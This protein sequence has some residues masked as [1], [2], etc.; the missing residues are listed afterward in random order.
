[1][2]DENRLSTEQLV[3]AGYPEDFYERTPEERDALIAEID[4]KNAARPPEIPA[5]AND[6]DPAPLPAVAETANIDPEAAALAANPT[7]APVDHEAEQNAADL[8]SGKAEPEGTV[9]TVRDGQHPTLSASETEDVQAVRDAIVPGTSGPGDGMTPVTAPTVDGVVVGDAYHAGGGDIADLDTTEDGVTDMTYFDRLAARICTA[10]LD[11]Y[12][13]WHVIGNTKAAR[14]IVY[15][16]E[17]FNG[18]F[19]KVI[20]LS[21]G[22]IGLADRVVDRA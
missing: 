11:E 20:S 14:S 4:S 8:M 21:K 7:P 17:A 3:A 22:Q 9:E 6:V 16:P 1:M 19:E 12:G 13:Q 2:T 10:Q 15:S 5:G 18:R